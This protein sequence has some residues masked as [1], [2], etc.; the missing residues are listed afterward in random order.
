MKEMVPFPAMGGCKKK[1][2]SANREEVIP[3]LS[4]ST[5]ILNFLA[6][7]TMRDTFV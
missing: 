6:S 3:R 1:V 2:A 5:L 4:A 7:R